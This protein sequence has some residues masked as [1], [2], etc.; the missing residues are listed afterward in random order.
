M[1]YGKKNI[2]KTVNGKRSQAAASLDLVV[3]SSF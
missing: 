2:K 3:E 1:N